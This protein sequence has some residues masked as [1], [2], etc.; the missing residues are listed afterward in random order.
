M[1]PEI[2][3]HVYTMSNSE[4]QGLRFYAFILP[5]DPFSSMEH[6]LNIAEETLV[7]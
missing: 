1:Q 7:S 3:T 4:S 6:H 2:N 5:V